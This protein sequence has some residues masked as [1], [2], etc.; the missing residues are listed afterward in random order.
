MPSSTCS[1][2]GNSRDFWHL[3]E[4]AELLAVQQEAYSAYAAGQVNDP[5]RVLDYIAA[6]QQ[7]ILFDKGRTKTPVPDELKNITLQ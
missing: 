5:K 4:Y 1:S 6:K 7:Q 2:E 3:P